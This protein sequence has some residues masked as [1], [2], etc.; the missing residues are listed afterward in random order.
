MWVSRTVPS[1]T[2]NSQVPLLESEGFPW[3]RYSPA[4]IL[5]L[6]AP[7]ELLP[8]WVNTEGASPVQEVFVSHIQGV[9]GEVLGAIGSLSLPPLNFFV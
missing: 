7:P 4:C 2:V 8:C 3:Q 9:H 1:S 6:C 5:C